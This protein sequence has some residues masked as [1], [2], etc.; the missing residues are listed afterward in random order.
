MTDNVVILVPNW[1]GGID[2]LFENIGEDGESE[3]EVTTFNTHGRSLFGLS[4]LPFKLV[5]YTSAL[6]Y[7]LLLPF[8]LTW[9]ALF[10][11]LGKIDVC[12]INLSTGA[13]TVRK[14]L[15]AAICRLF[16]VKYVI[17]L[18]GGDYR[19]F[20]SQL[21]ATL[22][23]F[24]RTLYTRAS[25]VLVLGSLWRDYV[26]N[27]IGVPPERIVILPN[28]VPGPDRVAW[29]DKV[30]PPRIVFLGRLTREKGIVELVEALSDP[31]VA[32]LAWSAIL[33]GDGEIAKYR[34]AIAQLGLA[35]RVQIPGWIDAPDVEHA[36]S[37]ASIFVLP[38]YY[39][40]L[41]LS[42]LEAMA[43]GLCCVVTPVGSVG[44]VVADGVNGVIVPVR[45][46]ARLADALR[47]LLTD[48]QRRRRLAERARSDFMARYD[49]AGYRQQL[50]NVYRAVLANRD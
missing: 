34:H 11:M 41:P 22:Q 29:N 33:A 4:F 20:F 36:L 25:R 39:E 15:F 19:R 6:F 27:E 23:R 2:R 24:V 31:G 10:C 12:H 8:R 45:D 44:D 38:S 35:D 28:A 40:N 21:P 47:S 32:S 13:S 16:G 37:R 9:F 18:H 30:E 43:Y 50:D 49:Y 7:T 1:N 48:G 14:I 46:S 5:Y 26:T 17:H 42:L 3:F